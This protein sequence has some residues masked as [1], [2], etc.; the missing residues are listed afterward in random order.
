MSRLL[1]GSPGTI[2]GP[3]SPPLSSP[4]RL[5]SRRPP[6]S[7]VGLGRMAAEA[8]LDEN[9]PDLLLE[10]LDAGRIGRGGG[11]RQSG[12]GSEAAGGFARW[13]GDD[14]TTPGR[15]RRDPPGPGGYIRTMH[16]ILLALLCIAADPAKPDADGW[17]DLFNGKDLDGWVRR[18]GEAK[19]TRRR[20]R[21]R[22]PVGAEY[23][24]LVPVHDQDLSRFRPRARLQGRRRPEL[25]RAGPQRVRRGRQDGR[26]GRQEDQGPQARRHASSATRSKSIPTSS[27]AGCGPAASTTRA[28]AAGSRT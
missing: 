8:V 6:L 21:D 18:G 12:E 2:A 23:A 16:A 1:S 24:E 13:A 27:A 9:G 20:R 19:Y 17:I 14:C 11:R 22:R 15:I 26:V 28:A 3:V 10:E 7:F 25:R 5:S 4:A